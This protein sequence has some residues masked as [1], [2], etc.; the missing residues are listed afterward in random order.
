M[1][2]NKLFEFLN[3]YT[4]LSEEETKIIKNS[5]TPKKIKKGQILINK[6]EPCNR[7]FFI[8]KGLLRAF[9][10][11]ENGEEFTRRIAWE[12]GFLTNMNSFRMGGKNNSETIECIEKAVILEV[13][14][15]EF[16]KIINYSANL[17]TLYNKILEKYIAIN[18]RRYQHISCTPLEKLIYFNENYPA[19]KNRI[20]DRVLASFLSISR[21]TLLRAKKELLKKQ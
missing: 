5:F 18:I 8:N 6:N 3:E 19:L 1:E 11:T 20:N 13:R 17:F 16:Q 2:H 10:I 15:I 7:L 14:Y 9:L 4:K 21:A 12:N